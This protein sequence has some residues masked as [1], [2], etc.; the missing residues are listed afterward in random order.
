M[1]FP[2]TLLR[3]LSNLALIA[4]LAG[5]VE[6]RY[7]EPGNGTDVTAYDE[8][9]L[10]YLVSRTLEAA[11][12]I[13]FGSRDTTL[14][15]SIDG[16]ELSFVERQYSILD[17]VP[18]PHKLVFVNENFFGPNDYTEVD[19]DLKAWHTY[20]PH[21]DHDNH[22]YIIEK[23]GRQFSYFDKGPI[24]ARGRPVSGP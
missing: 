14:L 5:C 2:S 16:N 9:D 6:M 1:S 17:L 23:P 13:S 7:A 8:K 11:S 20:V 15:T 10:T 12:F 24:V 3:H 19:L 22:L 21:L 18:G 4:W